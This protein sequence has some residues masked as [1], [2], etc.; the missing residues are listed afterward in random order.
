MANLVGESSDPGVAAVHGTHTKGE[1]GAA[2][3]IGQGEG[4]G[5][6]GISGIGQGVWGHSDS[7]TGVVG[8]SKTG[9]GASGESNESTGVVAVSTSGI[10]LH[11]STKTGEAAVRGDHIGGGLAGLFNGSVGVT[12]DLVVSGKGT[13]QGELGVGG[14]RVRGT[15]VEPSEFEAIGQVLQRLT[16]LEQRLSG[17]EQKV[18]ALQNQVNT[19]VSNLEARITQAEFRIA[20]VAASIHTH[21]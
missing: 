3:I 13:I 18:S 19:A 12:R 15:L 11:A 7:S 9:I 14:L 1:G 2:A 8:V 20:G 4:R 10:G 6:L 17:V 21:S 5:L 16:A